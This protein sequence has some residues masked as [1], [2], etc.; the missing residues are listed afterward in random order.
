MCGRYPTAHL[1]WAEIYALLEGF[2]EGWDAPQDDPPERYN[3]APTQMAPIVT[4][5]GNNRAAGCMA[6][7]D[8]V[9]NFHKGPLEAKK[10]SSFNAKLETCAASPAFRQAV[11]HRRCLVPNRGFF[12]W[13]K[14]EGSKHPMLLES[15]DGGICFFA[16]LW[17]E[18]SGEHKGVDVYFTSFTI[19]TCPPN[20][21]AAQVHD[22]MPV[23]LL[24]EDYQAWL[25]GEA[26]DALARAGP[27]PAQLMRM[28][29]V[30]PLL[31]NVRNDHPALIA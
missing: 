1:R 26:P 29:A 10:W 7:W 23:I 4:A 25:F 19:L 17:D 14:I 16:G 3:I 13:R 27:H 22:R 18:W 15:V 30:N 28:R 11:R 21:L 24:P 12:E 2:L 9:P 31:G 8:F 5:A 6:R 20:A